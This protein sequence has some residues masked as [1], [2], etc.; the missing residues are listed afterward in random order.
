MSDGN[1]K[2]SDNGI[3]Y[4]VKKSYYCDDKQRAIAYGRALL[5]A[6]LTK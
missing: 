6:L 3:D 5:N 1:D 2:C 4:V